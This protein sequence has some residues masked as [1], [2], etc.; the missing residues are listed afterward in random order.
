MATVF[1]MTNL[2]GDEEGTDKRITIFLMPNGACVY[3]VESSP[4]AKHWIARR[5][6]TNFNVTSI[7]FATNE[8]I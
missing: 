6:T 8:L 5:I 7:G 1:G 2:M 4:T 3:I